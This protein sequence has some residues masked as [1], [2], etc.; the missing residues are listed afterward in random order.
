MTP[1][2]RH[3]VEFIRRSTRGVCRYAEWAEK[4]GADF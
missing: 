4:R 1:E 3:F 2:V